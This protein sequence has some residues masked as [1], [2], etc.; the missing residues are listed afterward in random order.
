MKK[1][2]LISAMVLGGL[3]IKTADAQF[4]I[5]INLHLGTRPVYVAPQPVYDDYY[6]LPE[7]EAY[8]SVAENCYYYHDGDN[9][10]SA[11][12]LPGRYHDF[13]WRS[14]K[15][16]EI[17]ENRPFMHHDIYRGK[18]GGYANRSDFYAR[19]YPNHNRYNDSRGGHDQYDN[20]NNWNNQGRG[21]DDRYNDHSQNGY[22]QPAP[23]R[24]HD[25]YQQ[26]TQHQ[27]QGG[28]NQQNQGW[29]RGGRGNEQPS[30]GQVQNQG[31]INTQPASHTGGHDRS[32]GGDEHF[33]T[34]KMGVTNDRGQMNRPTR[35]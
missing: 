30:R 18:F 34:N 20:R 25:G 21:G 29:G 27:N 17:H 31:G 35:F 9:W 22:S 16:Y 26:P 11:A 4:G 13:D 33:A 14:A 7:V 23:D 2:I 5:R 15:R 12:F 32:N 1:L 19:A 28:Y 6:Y 3:G 24:N 8:Y 10:I